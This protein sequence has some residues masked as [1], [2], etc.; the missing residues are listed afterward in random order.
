MPYRSSK[1]AKSADGGSTAVNECS[2]TPKF[3][4]QPALDW[5]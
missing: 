2:A 3:N 1:F 4:A 5:R